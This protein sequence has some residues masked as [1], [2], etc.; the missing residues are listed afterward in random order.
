MKFVLALLSDCP[1]YTYN[2]HI[3]YV[4]NVDDNDAFYYLCKTGN[5]LGIVLTHIDDF[6]LA[7]TE[8][9]VKTILDS[10]SRHVIHR[11]E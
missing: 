5:L 3:T 6:T 11:N 10:V 8:G 1:N 9:F 4:L 2:I 7:G